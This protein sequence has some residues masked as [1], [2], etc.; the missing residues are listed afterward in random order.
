MC[1]LRLMFLTFI[2]LDVNGRLRLVVAQVVRSIRTMVSRAQWD[3]LSVGAAVMVCEG[4][5]FL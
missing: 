2:H 1:G 5:S 3:D 4:D